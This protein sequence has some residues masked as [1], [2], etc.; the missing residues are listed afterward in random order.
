MKKNSIRPRE[1]LKTKTLHVPGYSLGRKIRTALSRQSARLGK[2]LNSGQRHLGIRTTA[3]LVVLLWVM[4]F[5][6]FT[7]LLLSLF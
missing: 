2:A 6:Y 4:A 7:N 1:G 3:V 5:C